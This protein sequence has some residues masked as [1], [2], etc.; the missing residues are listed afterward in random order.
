MLSSRRI[1][2]V[3]E[4]Q[5]PIESIAT[6]CAICSDLQQIP[7]LVARSTCPASAPLDPANEIPAPSAPLVTPSIVWF[8]ISIING[9]MA[10]V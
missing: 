5:S 8:E 9:N 3:S 2:D 7:F 1:P 6:T 4:S 10:I